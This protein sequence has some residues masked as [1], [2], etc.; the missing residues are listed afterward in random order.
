MILMKGCNPFVSVPENL[1]DTQFIQP[2]G[3]GSGGECQG[4]SC[5]IVRFYTRSMKIYI[6]TVLPNLIRLS[7]GLYGSTIN[8]RRS[9]YKKIG[10]TCES[11]L[12]SIFAQR[13]IE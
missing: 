11:R 7:T 10:H 3:D 12:S 8:K 2:I 5:A 9:G 13:R 4:D 6:T 1:V